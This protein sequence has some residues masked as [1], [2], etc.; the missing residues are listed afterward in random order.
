[1]KNIVKKYPQIIWV[2]LNP[3]IPKDFMI[4]GLPIYRDDDHINPYG[5]RKIAEHF[6]EKEILIKK[7]L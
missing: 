3:Y 5:A 7:V 6:A 4:N 1:M 2:D